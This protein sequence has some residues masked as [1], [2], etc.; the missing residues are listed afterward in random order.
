MEECNVEDGKWKD[1]AKRI[2]VEDQEVMGQFAVGNLQL[3]V[4]S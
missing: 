3:A 2:L 1:N 4:S